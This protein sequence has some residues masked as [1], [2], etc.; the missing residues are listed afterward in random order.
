MNGPNIF[1]PL[2]LKDWVQA[3]KHAKLCPSDTKTWIIRLDENGKLKWQLL[4]IHAAVIF[5]APANVI[6][7]L[8]DVFPEGSKCIDDLGMTPLQ[9]E[10]NKKD[11]KKNVLSFSQKQ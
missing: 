9:R 1:N 6:N 10:I 4:P 5:N 7:C 8:L 3:I 2:K 11:R